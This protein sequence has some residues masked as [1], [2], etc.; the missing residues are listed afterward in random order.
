MPRK[1]RAWLLA[2]GVIFVL[3]MV[4]VLFLFVGRT[5]PSPPLPNPNGYDDFRRAGQAV[6]GNLDEFSDLDH[7]GLRALVVSNAEALR[8]LRVGLTH[9][10]AV[11]TDAAIA[12]LAAVN[13]DLIALKSLAKMLCAEGRLAEMENRPGDAAHS[14]IDAIRLGTEMS[15]GGLLIHRLVCIAC[16]GMGSQA[17]SKL[18]P[19]LTC[20]QMWPLVAELEGIDGSTITWEEVLRNENRFVRGQMGKYHNPIKLV[21]DYWQ[22]RSTLRTK[23]DRHDL[24]VAHLRLLTT[25]LALRCYQCDHRST[26]GSLQQLVPKY[27]QAVPSDPFSSHPL[28]YRPAGTNWLLYSL[29]PD[30]VDDGGKP[31]GKIISGDFPGFV[32]SK[33][34][35]SPNKGDLLFDS[36]W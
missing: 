16:E 18:L 11:P 14:Y 1:I 31:V 20:E 2:L 15:H 9:R 4:T 32:A 25:E 8:M 19:R 21:S 10:C 28:V 22:V 33:S 26:P 5:P 35:G 34:D 29:G 36:P 24:A 13:H 12:N 23:E 6:A 27:L 7:E 3:A 17:V 30:R